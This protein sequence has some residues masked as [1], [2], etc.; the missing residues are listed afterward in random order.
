MGIALLALSG[1]FKNLPSFTTR[2]P[3]QALPKRH[4][5]R[6]HPEWAVRS[7]PCA[8]PSHSQALPTKRQPSLRVVHVHESG[9]SAA[10]SGRMVISGRMADVCAELDRL[11]AMEARCRPH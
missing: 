6:V 2:T 5:V 7:V 1:L 8:T 4:A 11:V 10:G 3:S 9:Q